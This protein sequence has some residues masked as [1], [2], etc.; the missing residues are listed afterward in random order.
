MVATRGGVTGSVRMLLALPALIAPFAFASPAAAAN[1]PADCAVPPDLDLTQFNVIIGTN[2]SE[3]LRGTGGPDFVCARLGSDVIFGFGG[4]DI[5]LG[6]TTTFFGDL[7]ARGGHDI[8]Y[9]GSGADQVLSGPGTT[10][11]GVRPVATSWRWRWA[12]TSA[13]VGRAP[14][15]SSAASAATPSTAAP[16]ATTSLA[17][18]TPT[19]CTAARATTRCTANCLAAGY[20]LTTRLPATS[21]TA[22]PGPTA[23][24]TATSGSRSRARARPAPGCSARHPSGSKPGSVPSSSRARR[25]SSGVSCCSARVTCWSPSSKV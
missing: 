17:V 6:D 23:A 13:T 19:P 25:S 11:P 14:T 10:G 24:P 2:S 16:R 12:P 7:N 5:I 1:L 20:R 8:I 22:A 21:A 15:T 4:D 3:T 9:A 18:P